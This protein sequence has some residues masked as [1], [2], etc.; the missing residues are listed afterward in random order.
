MTWLWIYITWME[1]VGVI[2]VIYALGEGKKRFDIRKAAACLLVNAL[3]YGLYWYYQLPASWSLVSYLFLFGY[4]CWCYRGTM[5]RNLSILVISL[6]IVSV[7]ELLSTQ[8]L[9]WILPIDLKPGML[10]IVVSSFVVVV[11]LFLTRVKFYRLLGF[12]DKWEPSYA[13]VAILSLMIFTPVVMLRILKK[14]NMTDYIYI[15]ICIVVMWLLLSKIQKYNLENRIRKKYLEGFTD[16]IAQI[17]RRQHK[18]KN[19]F[20]TAFGL[21]RLY[22]TYEELVD[23]QKEYLGRLWDYELPTDAVIL[24]EPIVVAL[25]YEKINEAIERGI[26]V[27]T[28]F[29]CSLADQNIQDVIWVQ[30]LGALLDNAIE[31]L[32]TYEGTK[33]LWI[34]IEEAEEEE[35]AHVSIR[36]TNPSRKFH[37]AELE[38]MF[39]MGYSSK[40]KDRGIG[41]YDVKE[42]VHKCKGELIVESIRRGSDNCFQIRILL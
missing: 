36:V 3:F 13:L 40:G 22:D 16:S 29:S 33:K 14:L 9:Y 30:I 15:A 42:L 21:Y 2:L 17:R 37:H 23:K 10:E 1:W 20:N 41:L 34:E 12:M 35:K 27:E 39:E 8:I 5:I 11:C 25:L 6:I 18:V 4:I 38:K 24:E 32:D 19:Q 31:A 28:V 26:A 7:I